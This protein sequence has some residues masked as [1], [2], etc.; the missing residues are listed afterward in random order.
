MAAALQRLGI[1]FYCSAPALTALPSIALLSLGNVMTQS[2]LSFNP[3]KTC[4]TT[5]AQLKSPLIKYFNKGQAV[6]A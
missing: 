5:N 6:A 1:T 3:L 2:T 4:S